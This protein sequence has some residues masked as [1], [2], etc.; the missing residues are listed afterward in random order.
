MTDFAVETVEHDL[1]PLV[2]ALSRRLH[3]AGVP[4]TPERPA[5][6]ARALTLVRPVSRRRLYWTARAVLVSD[7]SQ[8]R[9]FDQVFFSI[10]GERD[11]GES[12]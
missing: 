8:V 4:M 7:P 5:Q 11:A 9:A 12:F 10:F 2:A 6:F 1:P 3:E